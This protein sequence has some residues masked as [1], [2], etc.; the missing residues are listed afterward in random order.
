V[1]ADGGPLPAAGP[2]RAIEITRRVAVETARR[3]E[4]LYESS[5]GEAG[6]VCAQVSP[7]IANDA[8]AMVT[9]ASEFA[10]WAL[11]VLVK[12]PVT[13]AGVEAIERCTAVGINITATVSFSLPQMVATAEAHERGKSAAKANGGSAG[14]CYAVVMLGR[15][16]DHLKRAAPE[17]DP[18]IVDWAGI[19][20]AKRA[21]VLFAE[22]GY[23]ATILPSGMRH[24]GHVTELAGG[25]FVF[26]V[27]PDMAAD[28]DG[29][30]Y[31]QVTRVA[32]PVDPAVIESLMDIPD[33]R[34]AYEPDG[35]NPSE[36]ADFGASE[37]TLSQFAREGWGVLE[38]YEL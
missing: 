15:L 36:F 26:S 10:S 31:E 35:M 28:L 34:R 30:D 3:L 8:S 25:E 19:A 37:F 2:E 6:Y 18:A 16:D 29:H 27:S 32:R 1:I 7:L 24:P 14:H 4:Q 20:V 5:N 11:N 33:F 23:S 38:R 17:A 9:Q 22:K 12:L 21:R 13:A